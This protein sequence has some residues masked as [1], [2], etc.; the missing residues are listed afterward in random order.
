MN[1]G[2][3]PGGSTTCFAVWGDTAYGYLQGRLIADGH[4]FVEYGMGLR[5]VTLGHA[6]GPVL[7]AVR[8]VLDRG[9]SFTF[10]AESVAGASGPST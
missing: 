9:V 4:W 10:G 7:D 6:Y 2:T 3:A 8:G 1:A 5:A